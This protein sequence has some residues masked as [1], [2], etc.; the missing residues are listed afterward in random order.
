MRF[1]VKDLGSAFAGKII[2]KR[3]IYSKLL[4]KMGREIGSYCYGYWT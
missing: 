3:L 1:A 2:A 4:R